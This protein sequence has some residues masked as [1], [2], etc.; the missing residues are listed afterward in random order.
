MSNTIRTPGRLVTIGETV[1]K[2]N[3][4]LFAKLDPETKAVL[5]VAVEE[6]PAKRIRQR[7]KPRLNQT[8]R[9][10][11]AWLKARLPAIQFEAH[12]L[13]L[14]LANGCLYSPD[15][16]GKGPTDEPLRVYEVKGKMAW[17]DA[18]V[19]LKVAARAWP[20]FRFWLIWRNLRTDPWQWQP[21]LA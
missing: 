4:H 18:I 3:P 20:M 17:D 9:D 21:V 2:L 19:K 8:E 14:E 5:D 13:T 10:A 15:I 1:R 6:A 12:A 11:L 7:S 16:V